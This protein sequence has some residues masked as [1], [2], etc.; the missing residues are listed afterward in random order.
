MIDVLAG[1]CIGVAIGLVFGM[2]IAFWMVGG[3]K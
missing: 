2:K 3:V 1:V